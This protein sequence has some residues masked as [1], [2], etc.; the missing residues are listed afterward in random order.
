MSIDLVV[1]NGSA[2]VLYRAV[3]ITQIERQLAHNA[4]GRNELV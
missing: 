3:E 1:L 2:Q 4:M